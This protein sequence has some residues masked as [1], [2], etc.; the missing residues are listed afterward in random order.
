[1][2]RR[3][4]T[5]SPHHTS[6]HRR[7]DRRRNEHGYTLIEVMI[8]SLLAGILLAGLAGWT[9]TSMRSLSQV[10]GWAIDQAG[11]DRINRT[12]VN[13]AATAL[14]IVTPTTGSPMLDCPG[15]TGSGGS[16]K[17]VMVTATKQRIVYSLAADS[18]ALTSKG[19]TLFRRACPNAEVTGST[20]FTQTDPLL[21]TTTTAATTGEGLA[22]GVAAA[23]ASCVASD[24][25]SL[26]PDC[27][28]V[29]LRIESANTELRSILAVATRRSDSYCRPGCRPEA[30]FTFSPADAQR[31]V[32][33]SF[34][35]AL[36]RDLRGNALVEW[37]WDFDQGG[38]TTEGLPCG[39]G[40]TG[41]PSAET[42]TSGAVLKRTFTTV[43]DTCPAYQVGLRVKNSEGTWSNWYSTAISPRLRRPTA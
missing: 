10:R 18:T 37:E 24:G 20:D 14:V 3:S 4:L 8:A 17:L 38:P 1:M 22:E 16:P 33:I 39:S 11:T 2:H 26:D 43:L 15:G 28:T 36:S 21:T 6:S 42:L 13:D 5:A 23:T 29:R 35:P 27:Q 12:L 40:I 25:A 7:T 41:G 30:K 19:Q 9:M 34:D 32:E 31:N